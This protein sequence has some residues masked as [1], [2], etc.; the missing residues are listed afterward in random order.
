MN[1]CHDC[2]KY[3]AAK[4]CMDSC[5]LWFCE[6]C[7]TRVH[8]GLCLKTHEF[9][10]VAEL[11]KFLK[12]RKEAKEAA[13]K[14]KGEAKVHEECDLCDDKLPHGATHPTCR[15]CRHGRGYDSDYD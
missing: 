1:L 10:T 12:E 4:L 7:W 6:A 5:G 14:A 11:E 9:F 2:D 15:K 3:P 8:S 13:A